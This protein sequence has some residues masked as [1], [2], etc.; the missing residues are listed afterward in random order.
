MPD[1]TKLLDGATVCI[2]DNKS[3]RDKNTKA[4]FKRRSRLS[5]TGRRT[6]KSWTPTNIYYYYYYY[7]Y[8]YYYQYSQ[9]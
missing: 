1:R 2:L 9:K 4:M 8:H 7:Y 3:Q 6:R 5:T